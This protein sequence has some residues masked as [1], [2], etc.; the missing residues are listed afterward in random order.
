MTHMDKHKYVSLE[1]KNIKYLYT[2]P[3][4]RHMYATRGRLSHLGRNINISGQ[5]VPKWNSITQVIEY[6]DR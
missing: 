5:H 2:Q 4:H 3:T 1:K 6:K